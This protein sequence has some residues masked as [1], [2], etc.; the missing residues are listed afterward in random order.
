MELEA[1]QL[2]LKKEEEEALLMARY[3]ARGRQLGF[4]YDFRD[5]MRIVAG[6]LG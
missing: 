3:E 4:K 5:A 2:R 1:S 6:R